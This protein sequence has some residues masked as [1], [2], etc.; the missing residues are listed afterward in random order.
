MGGEVRAGGKVGEER[1]YSHTADL[2][3]H[4]HCVQMALQVFV[5]IGHVC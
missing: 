4:I 2:A 5:Q 1:E 3:S